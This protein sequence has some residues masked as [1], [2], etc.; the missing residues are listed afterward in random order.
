MN[1]NELQAHREYFPNGQLKT[2]WFEKDGKIEGW[3]RHWLKNGQ[4]FSE[5]EYRDGLTNG[6]LREWSEDG[7]LI[8]LAHTKDGEFHGHYQAWW[9]DGLRKE[10][11]V[12]FHGKPTN[13]YRWYRVNGEFWK[14]RS[15]ESS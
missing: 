13:G 5:A 2:E 1:N 9:D 12:Y 7:R 15:D 4:L 3:R 6:V 10:E 14:E 8:L 11:G